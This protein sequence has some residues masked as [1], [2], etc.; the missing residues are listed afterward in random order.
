MNNGDPN[1]VARLVENWHEASRQH[2]AIC[3]NLKGIHVMTESIVQRIIF[4]GNKAIGVELVN[5]QHLKASKEIVVSCGALRTP[6][7]LMLS[8]IG[9]KSELSK[10][11]IS[12]VVELPVGE[13]LHDHGSIQMVWRLKNPEKGY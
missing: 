8:G 3:Y 13:H 9:T 7:V 4:D 6:Q 12:Q 5:G 2:A 1:G 11:S 10:H